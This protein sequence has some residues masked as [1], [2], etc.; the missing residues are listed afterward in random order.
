[1]MQTVEPKSQYPPSPEQLIQLYTGFLSNAVALA[2]ALY[3]P[4]GVPPLVAV[5]FT[6]P[7]ARWPGG[8]TAQAT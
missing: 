2:N 5:P 8:T 7:Q 6:L 3:G 1:M 4:R